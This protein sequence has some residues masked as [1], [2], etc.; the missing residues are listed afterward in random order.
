VGEEQKRKRERFSFVFFAVLAG[1]VSAGARVVVGRERESGLLPF[2]L[3]VR[4]LIGFL[5]V[6]L[7]VD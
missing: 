1:R 4:S 7:M 6:V 5:L 3:C 2:S